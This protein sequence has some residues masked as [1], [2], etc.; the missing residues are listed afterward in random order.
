VWAGGGGRGGGEQVA[1]RTMVGHDAAGRV[2]VV[3]VEG[4]ERDHRGLTIYAMA[5]LA[6]YLGMVNAVNLDG[7][8]GPG[9]AHKGTVAWPLLTYL[10]QVA[11]APRSCTAGAS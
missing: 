7:K 8:G 11:A 3:A 9:R 6:A 1:P 2:L 10:V 4:S 5:D